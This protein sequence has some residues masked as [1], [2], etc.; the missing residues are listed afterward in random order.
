ML[1]WLKYA[2]S[3]FSCQ[4]YLGNNCYY[5][6]FSLKLIDNL[7]LYIDTSMSFYFIFNVAVKMLKQISLY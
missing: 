1:I 7:Y 2:V 4:L 5:L 3:I 6:N